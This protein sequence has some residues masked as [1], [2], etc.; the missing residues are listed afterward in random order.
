MSGSP[1]NARCALITG[2]DSG[3]GAASARA[4]SEDGFDIAVV[5]HS[6]SEGA[7]RVCHDVVE[8]GQRATALQADVGLVQEMEDVFDHVG[9]Q[10]SPPS[11][12]VNSAGLN[13]TD[14]RV[15]D[16]DPADWDRLIRTDLSGAFYASRR[17]VRDRQK[18]GRGGAIVNISSIHATVMREGA[19]AYDAAK[20]GL[21]NLTRTMAL[22]CAR[23]GITVNSIEPGMILTPMN[24]RAAEEADYR[25]QL[26]GNIPLGRA[27][28]PEEVARLVSYLASPAAGY[29]TGAILV[30]DGGL[31]L[32]LGQGA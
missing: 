5:Y 8:R 32:V 3:I 30:I 15:A 13:M 12:L 28:R 31:S 18:T 7:E 4:L 26:E 19:A 22:E 25:R 24:E 1:G 10:L 6:D 2:G 23:Q 9:S 29:I 14:T 17:F 27:G 11:V 16:M 20:G 21:R